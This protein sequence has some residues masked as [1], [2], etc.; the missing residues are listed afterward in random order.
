MIKV[1]FVCLGNICRSPMA[2]FV[3]KDYLDKIGA[4]EKF[5]V[6]SAATSS[7][8]HGNPVHIGTKNILKSVGISTGNKTSIQ[9]KQQDFYTYDY[10]IGMDSENVKDLKQMAPKDAT[11]KI[12]SFLS[13]V[14]NFRKKDVPD[15][16][17]SGKF[18][19]TYNLV[20]LG[21]KYWFDML[22]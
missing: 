19:E 2:E 3:F 1:L 21:S 6:A 20:I 13:V 18:D 12:M 15:P 14:P 22:K 10:I 5:E 8:E 7:W 9:V 11:A 16:Y 4:S 17:Y